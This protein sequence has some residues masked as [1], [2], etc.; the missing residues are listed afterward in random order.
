MLLLPV[1]HALATEIYPNYLTS[2]V[3]RV[4]IWLA[5]FV[6]APYF[7]RH[8]RGWMDWLYRRK[9][10][11]LLWGTTLIPMG[12]FTLNVALFFMDG[13][14]ATGRSLLAAF[15]LLGVPLIVAAAWAVFVFSFLF[16]WK[17]PK[18][19]RLRKQMAALLS[20]RYGLY[21]GGLE[22]LMQDDDQLSMHLQRFLAEH[23]V[24][25][26]LPLY[27]ERGR[28]LAAMPQRAE[29]LGRAIVDA[30]GRGRDNELY[31]V[32]A[33]LLDLDDALEH[34]PTGGVSSLLQAVRVAR[35]RHHQMVVIQPWPHGL[36]LPQEKR[37]EMK[38]DTVNGMLTELLQRRMNESF[39]RLRR[40]FARLGVA[41]VCAE[42]E[43][44]TEL[45]LER[46]DRLRNVGGRR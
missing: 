45:I 9:R 8:W 23:R 10:A 15:G 2:E 1:A 39:F 14:P 42:S 16:S 4:P 3:N 41:V 11:I 34:S 25:Y 20:V 17:Q 6:G 37:P 38:R 31:V 24:P 28:Y 29:I 43:A 21:P 46:M 13:I 7:T 12:V 44:A 30:A 33:D 32:L 5:W 35:A 36:P 27:D 40:E 22:A 26:T 19:F 18:E